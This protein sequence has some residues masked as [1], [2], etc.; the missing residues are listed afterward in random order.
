MKQIELHLLLLFHQSL[1]Q[2][3]VALVA[4]PHI[5]NQ[6]PASANLHRVINEVTKELYQ[7]LLVDKKLV[8]QQLDP[9]ITPRLKCLVLSCANVVQR[10]QRNLKTNWTFSEYIFTRKSTIV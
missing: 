2:G 5:L 6:L 4:T 10:S 8:L 7:K 9:N 3:A 1:M